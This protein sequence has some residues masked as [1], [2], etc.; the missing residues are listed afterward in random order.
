MMWVFGK[1][2]QPARGGNCMKR[3][4]APIAMMEARSVIFST[5]TLLIISL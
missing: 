3:P 4:A 2:P 1:G 5:I